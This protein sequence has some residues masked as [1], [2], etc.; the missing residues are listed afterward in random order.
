M[1]QPPSAELITM[2]A[3]HAFV[4]DLTLALGSSAV[5]GLLAHR[6]RQPALL[7]YLLSGLLIG[8]SGFGL[9]RDVEQIEGLAEIGVA[10]LLFAL[11]V[12]F[13]LAELRR[14][15]NIAIQGS[16]LQMG[17]PSFWSPY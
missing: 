6:L 10:F 4:L 1:F 7:G 12:E 14:V 8:P 9:L 2:A 5:G 3:D 11:G 17:A 16:L 13:S 15:R